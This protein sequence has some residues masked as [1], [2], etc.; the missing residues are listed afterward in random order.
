MRFNE[1]KVMESAATD[2][3]GA[4]L[5]AMGSGKLPGMANATDS[6]TGSTG[7]TGAVIDK[8]SARDNPI[9]VNEISDYL[10]SKGL[11]D[12]HRLGMLTNIK[13]ESSF[14]SGA[15]GDNGT[16]GGLFQHHGSRFTNMVNA[17][18]SDWS[19]D[20]QGQIDFA[21]SEPAGR[22]YLS[23]SF[24]SPYDATEWWTKKFEIPA[25]VNQ[26]VAIRQNYLKN[27]A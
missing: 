24:R 8:A 9:K 23:L 25:N 20:W 6:A 22:E 1:F 18:G 4:L 15:I 7:A 21:L 26:Q 2:S 12:A 14:N 5:T 17:V 11:D 19:T 27:F 13:A 10:K 16:S 3:L